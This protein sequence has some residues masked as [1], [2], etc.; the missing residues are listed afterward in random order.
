[1]WLIHWRSQDFV[2]KGPKNRGAVGAEFEMLKA[3][4]RRRMGRG[5]P[6]PQPRGLRERRKLSQRSPGGAP[7]ENRF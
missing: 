2:L 4:R 3:W 1:L 7:A 5:Y 6:P